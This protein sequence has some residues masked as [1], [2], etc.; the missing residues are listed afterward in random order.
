M[1][2]ATEP[3]ARAVPWT[4]GP[5]AAWPYAAH[6][7]PLAWLFGPAIAG[8]RILFLRDM[9]VTYW[10]D[11]AFLEQAL[12]QGV[13]PLWNPHA[14]AGTPFLKAYPLDLLLVGALGAPGALS[15]GVVLH[16]F[17][18]MCGMTWLA[19]REGVS[20]SGSWLAGTVYGLTGLSLSLVTVLQ[21]MQAA[22]W[23]PWVVGAYLGWLRR[24]AGVRAAMLG[25]L[26][27]LQVATLSAEIAFQTALVA[28]VLGVG[29][30]PALKRLPQLAAAG[31]V[32]LLLSAPATLGALDLVAGTRRAA[33]FAP[34]EVLALSA[35][36]GVL[37]EAL[38]PRFF[39]PPLWYAEAGGWGHAYFP[40]GV[41]YFVSAYVGLGAL[42]LALLGGARLWGL[43]LLGVALALGEHGPFAAPLSMLALVRFPQKY[44]FL[45]A[46]A[47]AL[48]AGRGLD[49]LAADRSS[50]RW[51]AAVPGGL[52]LLASVALRV[53]PLSSCAVASELWP[54]LSSPDGGLTC[55]GN[56]PEA[57]LVSGV[58][59]TLAGLLAASRFATFAG[60]L[61]ALE[62]L[63]VNGP[64]NP[65]APR[66]FLSL[67]SE[68]RALVD[69]ARSLPGEGRFFSYGV[70]LGEGRGWRLPERGSRLIALHRLMRQ[71]L[72]QPT[73][74]LD[75]LDGAL[76]LG[77]TGWEPDGST[78]P[79]EDNRPDRFLRSYRELRLAGI[80]FVFS[81][82]PLPGDP[83]LCELV[84]VARVE[85]TESPLRLCALGAA[86]PRA[87]WVP[88]CVS[89]PNAV[90]ARARAS[91]PAFDPRAEVAIEDV[92]PCATAAA[93]GSVHE[94]VLYRRLGPHRV[95]VEAHTA[96]GWI[97]VLE[98]YHPSWHA[99]SDG[100]VVP[101]HRANGR[102]WAVATTGGAHSFDFSFEPAWPG[103]A[104][105]AGG[106]GLIAALGL[107]L[108]GRSEPISKSLER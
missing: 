84:G 20:A 108:F 82:V 64:L 25:L 94:R 76:D 11:Y 6:L 5:R 42:G 51:L 19:R 100:R 32:A 106:L 55:H 66:A 54:G 95:Q 38:L 39:G 72:T 45:S 81:F 101:L 37:T 31:L 98:S 17:L 22:A 69:T 41:P 92:S 10:P 9:L 30:R 65:L 67:D 99:R 53:A 86:L 88:R 77:R 96:P 105:A 62:L 21:L 8:T 33:G 78:L 85:G 103:R 104:A 16:L 87:F 18:G 59:A 49:R 107:A 79:R 74:V 80:E 4:T 90:A 43:V 50:P 12:S 29:E 58:L 13:W 3:G 71:S 28:L 26:V 57:W 61:V 70:N 48:L 60:P 97:V 52:V 46:F 35:N 47:I 73:Q 93:E 68:V 7:L 44:L 56:W 75:G 23:A 27:A 1:D 14:Y 2:G 15:W 40:G 89:A 83:A 102:Y 91:D 34:A 36:A 63:I 24:P